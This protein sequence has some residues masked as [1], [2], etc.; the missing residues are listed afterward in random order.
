MPSPD[1]PFTSLTSFA[2]LL[3]WDDLRLYQHRGAA[4][5]DANVATW[6]ESGQSDGLGSDL[7]LQINEAPA[8]QV[9]TYVGAVYALRYRICTGWHAFTLYDD[10]ERVAAEASSIA[11]W[12]HR[13]WWE[14]AARRREFRRLHPECAD[15]S[16]A[17]IRAEGPPYDQGGMRIALA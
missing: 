10:Q 16:W 3:G 15:Y 13:S 8:G 7:F 1:K 4:G 6:Y 2:K 9:S 12:L 5:D 14:S 17:R 11:A